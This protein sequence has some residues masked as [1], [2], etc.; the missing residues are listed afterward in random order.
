MAEKFS[1]LVLQ[2]LFATTALL[3]VAVMISPNKSV[4]LPAPEGVIKL[5]KTR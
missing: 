5:Y 2:G 4:E 3:F 1:V